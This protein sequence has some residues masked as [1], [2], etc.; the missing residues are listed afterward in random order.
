M[1]ER[2]TKLARQAGFTDFPDDKNGVW[3]TDGYW[4]EQLERFAELVLKEATLKE[5]SDIGQEI[6]PWDTSDMA[7]RSGGLSVEQAEKQE[8]KPWCDYLNIMLTSL[9]PQ[10]AKCNCKQAE[11]QEKLC[12]YCGGIGRV[13]CD[14]RCMPEQEPST[15][16]ETNDMV[17]ALLRQAH[18]VLAC[19][20][21]P[22][23]HPWVGLTEEE[24]DAAKD[25]AP[26]NLGGEYYREDVEKIAR[27]IEAKLKEKNS[28]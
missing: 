12:K 1:N 17:C 8:H 16:A 26:P 11:K 4:E 6:E 9:P 15:W 28:G 18:D 23:K 21:Y 25:V 22:F 3:I 19:A 20:S 2:I 7:H 24:I 13:V 14:G 5:M 10:K 27:A